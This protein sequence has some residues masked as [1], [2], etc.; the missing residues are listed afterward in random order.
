MSPAVRSPVLNRLLVGG[1]ATATAVVLVAAPA[2]A[3]T[4]S[5]VTSTPQG[6]AEANATGGRAATVDAPAAGAVSGVAAAAVAYRISSATCFSNDVRFTADT[7]ETGLS[8]VQRFRQAAQLQ[9]FTTRGWVPTTG[10]ATVTSATFP[11]DR[12]SIHFVRTWNGTHAANGA[13]WRVVWQ[14]F[15]YNGGGALVAKTRPVPVTCL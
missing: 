7:F 5:S 9:E 6:S 3:S 4:G 13:S 10:T 8:G 12:R 14:G 1:V 11:N 2:G 15:Y